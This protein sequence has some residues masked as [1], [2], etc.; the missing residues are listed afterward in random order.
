MAYPPR[1]I[2]FILASTDHGTLIVNRFDYR[3]VDATAG[4]G[5]GHFLLENSSYEA[6]EG[7][8]AMQLLAQRRLH[9]GAGVVAVDCGANIGVHTVE[10]AKGMTGWGFVVAIEA[11]ERI[12]YA[13]AG[14]VS[15]NNCFNA[16]AI[17]AAVGA[18]NGA[19]RIPVP[20]YLA[21]GSFGSLEL[22]QSDA[23]EFIGQVIDYSEQKLATI[24]M[25]TIDSLNLSRLDL[26]KIDVER[27][28]LEV[29]QGA[30]A[31]LERF[32]P[33]IIVEQLKA[34][35]EAITAVLASYGYEWFALGLNFLAVHPAD[36]TRKSIN[37][38]PPGTVP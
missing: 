38:V 31:T 15:I 18:Q 2:A 26:I 27:M 12:Y 21:P 6:H 34:S 9:F 33:I 28:E 16:H 22:R 14:N 23:N 1:K 11:Q 10:W 17:H 32:R 5:V 13:L 3:M 7:S 25:I 24:R 8:V 20:N 35:R 36:P 19:L 29:L 30:R 37:I 4:F